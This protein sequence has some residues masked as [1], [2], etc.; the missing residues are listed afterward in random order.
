MDSGRQTAGAEDGSADGGTDPAGEVRAAW[1]QRV[2]A[3]WADPDVADDDRVDRMRVLAGQAPHPALGAFELGG[4]LDSAGREAEADAQY[5]AATASGLRAVDAARAAQLAI[6]HASTLRN[7]GRVEEAI[8]MLRAA[9]AHEAVGAAPAVFLALALHSAGRTDE[10][11]RVA[12]EA[13]EP[14][15]PRY[16]RSVR[17]YAA[18]L[19]DD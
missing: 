15:L 6:Q 18:A 17:A 14:G 4:A 19:T 3:L 5:A 8:T 1:E 9:P 11:L 16:H 12:L 7:L 2:A 13:I 10:A